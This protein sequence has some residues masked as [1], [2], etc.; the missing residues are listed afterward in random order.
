MAAME[1]E[2]RDKSGRTI[3]RA[4]KISKTYLIMI[5]LLLRHLLT[6]QKW[7]LKGL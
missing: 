3:K 5:Q 4:E 6:Q 7:E 1:K 2:E